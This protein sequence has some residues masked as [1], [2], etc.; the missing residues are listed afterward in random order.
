MKATGPARPTSPA[1]GRFGQSLWNYASS[2]LFAVVTMV[3]GLVATPFLRDWLGTVR[4]GAVRTLTELTGYLGLLEL[5]LGTTLAPLLARALGR[6]DEPQLRQTMT[7]GVRIHCLVIL[8]I[9]LLGLLVIW[10]LPRL[11]PV[12]S[13]LVGELRIGWVI[14]LLGWFSLLSNPF[15]VL[16]EAE[17][18]GY[19]VN[20]ILL[21]QG[22]LVTALALI[23]ARSG[24]GLVGQ[25]LA[26]VTGS[27]L[28]AA[29]ITVRACR[30]RPG[31]LTAIVT[32]RVVPE[33]RANLLRV[34]R[35]T[36]LF[37]LGGQISLMTDYLVLGMLQGTTAGVT[38]LFCSQRLAVLAQQQ[39]ANVGSA[40]WASLIGLHHRGE[41]ER[42]NQ[43]LVELTGLVSVLGFAMLGP[44]VAYNHH[45]VA[46]WMGPETDAGAPVILVAAINALLQG[47]FSLWT[48][49]PTGTGQVSRLTAPALWGAGINLIAS[50]VLTRY[51]GIV[52]PLLGTLTGFLA[53]H[54]WFLPVLLR[55]LFGIRI[56]ELVERLVRTILLGVP[57]T[58]VLWLWTHAHTPRGW[59]GLAVEMALAAAGFLILSWWLL[60]GSAQRSLWRSRFL[61][62]GQ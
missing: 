32:E 60:L 59:L 9:L 17:N 42:F 23:L 57:Y 11:V 51:L 10:P 52:G 4:F 45:F 46:L 25:S 1:A 26:M 27:L 48:Y 3:T 55:R 38:M 40:T 37:K 50:V 18:R 2:L 12:D 43:K 35:P 58:L 44:I 13:P 7:A 29:V 34:G 41:H 5:G 49:A 30:I 53:V 20:L 62:T 61:R 19:R 54:A 56:R 24:W 16:V 31:L 6:D 47:L 15:R 39:I 8:V 14:G 22:L 33:T 21:A 36:V 28:G